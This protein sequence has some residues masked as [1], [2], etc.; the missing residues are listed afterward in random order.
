MERYRRR[1]DHESFISYMD[2]VFEGMVAYLDQCKYRKYKITKP[3]QYLND[4]LQEPE[5]RNMFMKKSDM[6]ELLLEAKDLYVS[7]PYQRTHC[8]LLDSYSLDTIEDVDGFCQ[9]LFEGDAVLDLDKLKT[10]MERAKARIAKELHLIERRGGLTPEELADKIMDG[11][12]NGALGIRYAEIAPYSHGYEV[13]FGG[14]GHVGSTWE[15]DN[16]WECYTDFFQIGQMIAAKIE[17][18][19]QSDRVFGADCKKLDIHKMLKAIEQMEQNKLKEF[20]PEAETDFTR[21][22]YLRTVASVMDVHAGKGL[23]GIVQHH[24]H[25]DYSTMTPVRQNSMVEMLVCLKGF[26]LDCLPSLDCSAENK[27]N[28]MEYL[29]RKGLDITTPEKLNDWIHKNPDKCALPHNR[30]R[31]KDLDSLLTSVKKEQEQEGKR[32]S[33]DQNLKKNSYMDYFK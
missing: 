14:N 31:G 5:V 33:L 22:T 10:D 2:E 27:R 8:N 13:T 25:G 18:D 16:R 32:P 17:A 6:K 7:D 4:I 26:C 24:Y 12:V 30:L 3:Y 21:N 23:D 1:G 28:I 19:A 15:F 9:R 20:T 11:I 29:K